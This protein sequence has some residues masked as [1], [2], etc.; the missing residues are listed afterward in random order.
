MF[1]HSDKMQKKNSEEVPLRLFLQETVE[2]E[3]V[4]PIC[5]VKQENDSTDNTG[6][7]VSPTFD[8]PPKNYTSRGEDGTNL[9]P[10]KRIKLEKDDSLTENEEIPSRSSKTSLQNIVNEVAQLLENKTNIPSLDSNEDSGEAVANNRNP[11][12]QKDIKGIESTG[13]QLQ[14][15]SHANDVTNEGSTG[16][17]DFESPRR[18]AT[19]GHSD[20]GRSGFP[21]WE[22]GRALTTTPILRKL[23]NLNSEVEEG[24][25]FDHD[26]LPKLVGVRS[27][28]SSS[29]STA[30]ELIPNLQQT[31]SPIPHEKAFSDQH[32][33][34]VICDE[35]EAADAHQFSTDACVP[36]KDSL[37]E[38]SVATVESPKRNDLL[39]IFPK[40]DR[41]KDMFLVIKEE[42][43]AVQ[44]F[45]HEG[46]SYLIHTDSKGKKTILAKEQRETDARSQRKSSRFAFIQRGKTRNILPA[47]T[48]QSRSMPCQ[49]NSTQQSRE[50]R[51]TVH[52]ALQ[53][54]SI[55]TSQTNVVETVCVPINA[56]EPHPVSSTLQL[57]SKQPLI[58]TNRKSAESLGCV[59]RPQAGQEKSP[60]GQLR[61]PAKAGAEP[62][63]LLINGL[64]QNLN[65]G[66]RSS[67][68]FPSRTVNTPSNSWSNQ[69][70]NV[71]RDLVTT[72]DLSGDVVIL[73]SRN[74]CGNSVTQSTIGDDR[75][76]LNT[77]TIDSELLALAKRT[78][79]PL[80]E[81]EE[82]PAVDSGCELLKSITD[83]FATSEKPVQQSLANPT[84]FADS[85]SRGIEAVRYSY[86]AV[87]MQRNTGT[88]SGEYRKMGNLLQS[89]GNAVSVSQDNAEQQHIR[90]K[91]TDRSDQRN[92]LN[93]PILQN[94]SI[95]RLQ[96]RSTA[97]DRS[98]DS[99]QGNFRSRAYGV[100]K[101]KTKILE[102]LES[103]KRCR[104]SNVSNRDCQ[105]LRQL[106][107]RTH[108]SVSSLQNS[109][110]MDKS[111]RATTVGKNTQGICKASSTTSVTPIITQVSYGISASST[112]G[113]IHL[114]KKSAT[115]LVINQGRP[116][117]VDATNSIIDEGRRSEN[118][119][120]RFLQV[121]NMVSGYHSNISGNVTISQP[122]SLGNSLT[123]N[124]GRQL[125]SGLISGRQLFYSPATTSST[126][127]LR[128][129]QRLSTSLAQFSA[130]KLEHSIVNNTLNAVNTSKSGTGGSVGLGG[131]Q[132][133]I[134]DSTSN[135]T[136][137]SAVTKERAVDKPR[138]FVESGVVANAGEAA[139]PFEIIEI[140]DSPPSL[141]STD[142][143]CNVTADFENKETDCVIVV[144]PPSSIAQLQSCVEQLPPVAGKPNDV[145]E[146]LNPSKAQV[147]T[148]QKKA[149]KDALRSK[150]EDAAKTHNEALRD[151]LVKKVNNARER[152]EQE[153]IEWKKS[154][155]NKLHTVL[156]KKL[157]KLPGTDPIVGDERNL[158]IDQNC[159]S[160]H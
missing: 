33:T 22:Q 88:H 52:P 53:N 38:N 86:D 141:D 30:S 85:S 104:Q 111:Q 107:N 137:S 32:S 50:V 120:Q 15:L 76:G 16:C 103:W 100:A 57:P 125:N 121:G 43:F 105:V 35:K 42:V 66:N 17:D 79:N 92:S 142:P 73:N 146:I 101:G 135:A 80:V 157:A 143:N 12:V 110:Q 14:D 113:D 139:K 153:K 13:G 75:Q 29:S 106:L 59:R 4:L 77:E 118:I 138:E 156:M 108:Q 145:V 136:K 24:F 132:S 144:E 47:A 19:D 94:G 7:L 99:L 72:I 46:E 49:E 68:H 83:N 124:E 1:D 60:A 26:L 8:L 63:N 70:S 114:P 18:H 54:N 112:G 41:T 93:Q 39:L 152:F 102:I 147:S 160:E 149:G 133:Y 126:S 37:L 148:Y 25:A 11:L 62:Q 129:D 71:I 3:E 9:P 122:A 28:L 51:W 45:H 6:Q 87:N 119:G 96:S 10:M 65:G 23:K 81:N 159:Y 117:Y 64:L 151:E 84:G 130:P 44:R 67:A 61:L 48:R 123:Q 90:N 5:I 21:A 31:S 115:A 116:I 74:Q 69:S 97:P 95:S 128:T 82:T 40:D 36:S 158:E 127:L 58:H 55:Q 34:E 98:F 134:S 154:R 131:K 140:V 89:L 91:Y 155:L 56:H 150:Q 2:N 78:R 109:G 20:A 27:V